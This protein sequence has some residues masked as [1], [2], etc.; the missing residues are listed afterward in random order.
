M[1]SGYKITL[2]ILT[3][4]ILVTMTIGT[5]YSYYMISGAQ[6]N[7][8]E[9]T[10]ACFEISFSEGSDAINLTAT[11]P[12]SDDNASTLSPYTFTIT[13]T[14]TGSNATTINYDVT[15]STITTTP[16]TLQTSL[17]K[18]RLDQTN[19]TSITGTP[20]LLSNANPYSFSTNIQSAYDLDT[21]YSLASG[22]L[23]PGASVTYNLRLWITESATTDIM[24][25]TFAGRVLVYSYL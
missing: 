24:G 6:T 3:I 20:S 18:Y 5:S 10:S 22:T 11:Y 12:M 14:C 23:S 8:N 19:P 17:L 15:L 21:S 7:P 4:M 13:N 1:R 25:D 2:G 16:S 9:I